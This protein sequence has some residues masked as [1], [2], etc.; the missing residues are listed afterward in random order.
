MVKRADE[1]ELFVMRPASVH[2]HRGP[3]RATTKEYHASSAPH[4][5]HGLLPHLRTTGGVDRDVGPAP[6]GHGAEIR[7][8]VGAGGGVHALADADRKSTRL[9][10]SHRCISYA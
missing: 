8:D 9:N 4:G 5:G 1:R 3:G 7:D 10:S 2:P 6:V